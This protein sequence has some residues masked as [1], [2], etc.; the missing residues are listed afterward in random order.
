MKVK[1]LDYSAMLNANQIMLASR[2]AGTQNTSLKF[3]QQ[4]IKSMES[5]YSLQAD[6]AKASQSARIVNNVMDTIQSIPSIV[7]IVQKSINTNEETEANSAYTETLGQFELEA[8][9]LKTAGKMFD[10]TGKYTDEY[11]ALKD[12][13]KAQF[14][15][16]DFSGTTRDNMKAALDGY[17]DSTYW[18]NLQDYI[19][20]KND[21]TAEMRGV[22]LDK[23]ITA[24]IEG[25][26]KD[27]AAAWKLIDSWKDLP[28]ETRNNLKGQ[29]ARQIASGDVQNKAELITDSS[30]YNDGKKYL[31]QARKNGDITQDEYDE[32]NAGIYTRHNKNLQM[33]TKEVVDTFSQTLQTS[34]NIVTA[35][36]EAMKI[37]DQAPEEDRETLKSA[38]DQVQLGQFVKEN[39]W[40]NEIEYMTPDGLQ[41]RID[42]VKEDKSGFFYGAEDTLKKPVLSTLQHQKEKTEAALQKAVDT[43]YKAQLKEQ[44]TGFKAIIDYQ[45]ALLN[46]PENGISAT[47]YVSN[48]RGAI[49]NFDLLDGTVEGETMIKEAINKMID[50]T[51]PGWYKNQYKSRVDGI[52]KALETAE[53]D[54]LD[55]E[56]LRDGVYGAVVDMLK[57]YG[58]NPIS[59]TQIASFLD[60]LSADTLGKTLKALSK[61]GDIKWS[62]GL[63]ED[64]AS[65][66]A[67]SDLLSSIMNSGLYY[68]DSN[69]FGDPNMGAVQGM[70]RQARTAWEQA[71]SVGEYVVNQV[72]P[73]GVSVESWAGTIANGAYVPTFSASDGK[74]YAVIP[75]DKRSIE[76][77]VRGKNGEWEEFKSISKSGE[78][79]DDNG[80]LKSL[81]TGENPFYR[82]PVLSSTYNGEQVSGIFPKLV[83]DNNSSKKLDPFTEQ[84]SWGKTYDAIEERIDSL[85]A[86]GMT[87]AQAARVVNHELFPEEFNTST[88]VTEN[89]KEKQESEAY[90]ADMRKE[91]DSL[92]ASGIDL[93]EAIK[94]VRRKKIPN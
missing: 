67:Y 20:S 49:K 87:P 60:S 36:D 57:D 45:T 85:I 58:R 52:M 86:D 59:E 3:N 33:T 91:V 48:L 72:L 14:D 65:V 5:I 73:E 10:S 89:A 77:C 55:V 75:G 15:G 6:A 23:A 83:G 11:N 38:I 18:S 8:D 29:V 79:R 61:S 40:Y 71:V 81:V 42:E 24:A 78:Y 31:D 16:M 94:T 88:N 90:Y 47:T 84:E 39:Q 50:T 51:I 43:E 70:T 12:K 92:I 93:V 54:G 28:E 30:G 82:R 17:A 35:R 63:M 69:S 22:Q 25:G 56:D 44:Q 37:V 9:A 27:T 13:Y 76:V 53:I 7:N 4:N 64:R 68:R 19:K 80:A 62:G 21:S 34:E 41:G 32:M 74:E 2:N 26:T 1:Q 46:D 66:G